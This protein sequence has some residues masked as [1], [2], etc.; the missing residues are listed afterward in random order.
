MQKSGGFAANIKAS[1]WYPDKLKEVKYPGVL[2]F[3]KIEF[4]AIFFIVFLEG[5]SN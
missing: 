1:N 4:F 3:K 5:L 2:A